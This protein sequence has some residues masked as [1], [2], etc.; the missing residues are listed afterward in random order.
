MR[1]SLRQVVLAVLSLIPL[2]RTNRVM[3]VRF[4]HA[5]INSTCPIAVNLILVDTETLTSRL[6]VPH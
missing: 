1:L 4:S 3:L 5:V 6:I 2:R